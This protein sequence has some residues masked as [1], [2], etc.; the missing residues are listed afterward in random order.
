MV[1]YVCGMGFYRIEDFVIYIIDVYLVLV[2]FVGF[3]CCWKDCIRN[4]MLFKVKYKFINYIR[5]YIGEK[6]FICNQFGCRKSFVC[7]ENLKIYVWIYMGERFFVC[8]FKGCDKCF[9]NLSDC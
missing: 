5:V 4:G 3:V 9:V 2:I 7:V 6:L 1:N 8:E